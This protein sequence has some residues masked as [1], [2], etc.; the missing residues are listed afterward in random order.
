MAFSCY[1]L[2]TANEELHPK[3]M[4]GVAKDLIGWDV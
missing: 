3:A 4:L 2:L 1:L